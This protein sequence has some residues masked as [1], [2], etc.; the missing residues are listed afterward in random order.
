MRW[1]WRNSSTMSSGT[2]SPAC[3]P[4]VASR[5]S[6]GHR[7]QVLPEPRAS[8]RVDHGIDA[9]AAGG[10]GHRFRHRRVAVAEDHVGAQCPHRVGLLGRSHRGDH[11]RPGQ[12]RRL[13][14]CARHAARRRRHQHRLARAHGRDR[15]HHRPRGRDHALGGGCRHEVVR[16]AQRD[17][18]TGRH[19]HQ[20][21]VAA[22]AIGAEHH[23]PLAQIGPPAPAGGTGP[24]RELLVRGDRVAVGD[25][26][27]VGPHR[28][29]GAGELSAQHPGHRERP[30]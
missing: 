9:A 4:Q 17:H 16:R 5:P 25:A 29:H 6:G 2:T 12:T 30:A 24:A 27:D 8:G 13:H 22:P 19:R 18:R 20:L 26:L 15:H 23:E 10:L 28:D 7:R 14:G 1:P 11:A 3:A 21:R